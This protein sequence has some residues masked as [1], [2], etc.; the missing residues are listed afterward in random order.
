MVRAASSSGQSQL[1]RQNHWLYA[2]NR[3]L[4]LDSLPE[5]LSLTISHGVFIDVVGHQHNVKAVMQCVSIYSI[6]R[7]IPKYYKSQD[8]GPF[9]RIDLARIY[10]RRPLASWQAIPSRVC[11]IPVYRYASSYAK[12]GNIRRML[13]LSPKSREQ[14]K[15]APCCLFVKECSANVWAIVAL[16]H[17]ATPFNQQ[18]HLSLWFASIHHLATTLLFVCFL[19]MFHLPYIFY[20]GIQTYISIYRARDH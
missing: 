16:P 9:I 20:L 7:T 6:N 10:E 12:V 14:K 15:L 2:L 13:R 11:K 19:D 5:P 17:P 4:I 8:N 18:T 1:V 3:L